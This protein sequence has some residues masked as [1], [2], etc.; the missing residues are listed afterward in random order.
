[1]QSESHAPSQPVRPIVIGTAIGPG[2]ENNS[3]RTPT[4]SLA[5]HE[6]QQADV[7]LESSD[8]SHAKAAIRFPAAEMSLKLI[9]RDLLTRPST[10]LGRE[11]E[12]Q[13]EY[14]TTKKDAG[15]AVAGKVG[16]NFI[17]GEGSVFYLE[18][19]GEAQKCRVEAEI[20][21]IAGHFAGHIVCRTLEILPSA[22]VEGEI[23]Y[24]EVCVQLGAK[25]EASHRMIG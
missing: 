22:K 16:A 5:S 14:K 23:T 24:A 6:L 13:G 12:F 1:M 11:T 18:A 10:K 4:T 9:S 20:V 7:S 25:V 19:S 21:V 15:I 17:L 2:S 3:S 8:T